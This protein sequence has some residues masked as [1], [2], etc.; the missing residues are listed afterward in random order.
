MDININY[1]YSI[2]SDDISNCIFLPKEIDILYAEKLLKSDGRYCMCYF[3]NNY[4]KA[5]NYIAGSINTIALDFDDN[6]TIDEFK[7]RAKKLYYVLGTT[8]NHQKLKNGIIADRFRVLLPLAEAFSLS[9]WEYG[10]MMDE[11]NRFF[12]SDP[13]CRDV[14]R[15]YR[16][17][18]DAHVEYNIGELFDWNVFLDKAVKRLK[19]KNFYNEKIQENQRSSNYHKKH[20]ANNPNANFFA[21]AK[22]VFDR[23]YYSGNRNNTIA[24]ILLWGIDQGIDY[25]KLIIT[26]RAWVEGSNDPLPSRE[27]EFMFRYHSKRV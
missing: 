10:I 11:V 13:A 16:G 25:N 19:I 4:R 24:R 23:N 12:G 6:V 15:Q 2:N 26:L 22:R 7:E 17:N 5:E 8:K 1:S 21:V 3:N 20:I 9:A 18:P 14:S 27:L